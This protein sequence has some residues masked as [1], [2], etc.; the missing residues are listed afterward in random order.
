M[1]EYL[2]SFFKP[3]PPLS[4]PWIYSNN[5]DEYEIIRVKIIKSGG[6]KSWYRFHIGEW[7]YVKSYTN[8]NFVMYDLHPH[9]SNLKKL[10]DTEKPSGSHYKNKNY[11][12]LSDLTSH[13]IIKNDAVTKKQLRKEK[14]KRILNEF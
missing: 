13:I 14:L 1:I 9:F 11:S 12:K 7:F 5:I 3:K 4:K 8:Q 10:I 6:T 2:K